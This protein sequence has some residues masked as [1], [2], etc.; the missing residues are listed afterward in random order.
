MVSQTEGQHRLTCCTWPSLWRGGVQTHSSTLLARVTPCSSSSLARSLVIWQA[1]M[2]TAT[3]CKGPQVHEQ[4][5]NGVRCNPR[6]GVLPQYSI[7]VR[8]PTHRKLLVS[9]AESEL[10]QIR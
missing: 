4:A 2:S 1:C 3:A 9:V 8:C 10:L 7:P 6:G 5:S